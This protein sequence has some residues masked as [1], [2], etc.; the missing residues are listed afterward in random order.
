VRGVERI[1]PLESTLLALVLFVGRR[2]RLEKGSFNV[3]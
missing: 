2:V 1:R 3:Q